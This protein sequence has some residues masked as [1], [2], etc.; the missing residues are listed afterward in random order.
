MLPDERGAGFGGAILAGDAVYDMMPQ[1]AFGHL[2][3][4]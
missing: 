4:G 1:Q 2:A 3:T